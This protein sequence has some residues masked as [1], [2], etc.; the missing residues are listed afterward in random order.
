M[1]ERDTRLLP[2]LIASLDTL[3]N[4][5]EIA[6]VVRQIRRIAG[7]GFFERGVP[8]VIPIPVGEIW[9]DHPD[10]EIAVRIRGLGLMLR[11]ASDPHP[12][13]AAALH[14]TREAMISGGAVACR[15]LVV[16]LGCLRDIIV[17]EGERRVNVPRPPVP[18]PPSLGFSMTEELRDSMDLLFGRMRG[19]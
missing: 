18:R 1:S 15:D 2:R 16:T 6:G 9:L 5:A 3:D 11:L 19:S 7:A 10:R 13:I 14:R 12:D 17:R 8:D 4:D